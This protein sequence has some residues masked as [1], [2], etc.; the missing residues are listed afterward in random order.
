MT[1]IVELFADLDGRQ[2]YEDALVVWAA[3]SRARAVEN[4]RQWR[5]R[6]PDKWRISRRNSRKRWLKR[7]PDKA[8]AIKQR[9]RAKNIERVREWNR[10]NQRACRARK[11]QQQ[12]AAA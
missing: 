9:Y 2:R 4:T 11:A 12:Q 5:K 6:N 10:R 3:F 8:K 7:N 1:G